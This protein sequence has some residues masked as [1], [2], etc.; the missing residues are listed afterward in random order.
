MLISQLKIFGFR[1]IETASLNTNK[2]VNVFYGKNGSGKTSILEAL[3][4]LSRAKSFR[5]SKKG[6]LLRDGSSLLAV[7]ADLQQHLE[8]HKLGIGLEGKGTTKLKLDGEVV[9]KLSQASI[10][11]PTQLITPESFDIFWSSPKARRSFFDFGLFHVEHEFQNEWNVYS[12]ILKQTNALLRRGGVNQKELL[13]WYRGLVE[14]ANKIDHFRELFLEEHFSKAIKELALELEHNEKTDLLKNLL[15][16]YK[17]KAFEQ[18]ISDDS[19]LKQIEK[20]IKYKQVGFGPNRADYL[21][22]RDGEDMSSRL[23]RGQ[24]KMLFYLLVVAMVNIIKQT[25][26]KNILLLVDDLPSEVDQQTRQ[27]MLE[28]LLHSQAQIFVTGIENNIAMEFMNY[29]DSVNVFHVEHGTVRQESMEQL[30]P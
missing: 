6:E 2:R 14:S 13:Y 27:T 9:T 19:L 22:L 1:N 4:F 17:K 29:T 24:A 30:C 18:E 16:R 10:L 5:T 7:S 3:F 28:M 12:K 21:F 20:D 11:F 15:M 26:K 23:S 25:T 8:T